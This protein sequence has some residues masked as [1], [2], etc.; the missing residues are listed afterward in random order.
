MR[1]VPKRRI[2]EIMNRIDCPDD[3]ECYKSGFENLCPQE[4]TECNV[5]ADSQ[6]RCTED[7]MRQC[8]MRVSSSRDY[9][10]RCPL[11]IYVAT[12][13]NNLTAIEGPLSRAASPSGQRDDS[14]GET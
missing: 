14:R 6:H 1:H 4:V 8:P 11:R 12:Y 3:F 13:L 2:Q 9:C 5:T 7:N 10:C